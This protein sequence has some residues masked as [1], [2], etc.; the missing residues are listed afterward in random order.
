[1]TGFLPGNSDL[2]LEIREDVGERFDVAKL[3]DDLLVLN[4]ALL[5]MFAVLGRNQEFVGTFLRR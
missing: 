5:R 4:G 3:L 1:M 2:G